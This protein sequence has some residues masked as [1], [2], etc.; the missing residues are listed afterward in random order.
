LRRRRGHVEEGPA[1]LVPQRES[2]GELLPRER[3]ERRGVSGFRGSE[4]VIV[5]DLKLFSPVSISMS[6]ALDVLTGRWG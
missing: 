4:E 2:S 6:M 3:F 5:F 1:V